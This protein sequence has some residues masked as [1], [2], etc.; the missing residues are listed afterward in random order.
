VNTPISLDELIR[1]VAK[2]REVDLKDLLSSKRTQKISNTRAI[3]SYLAAIE[4]RNSGK[5]IAPY[6]NLSEKSV[7]RCI[8][9]G[10]KLLDKDENLLDYVH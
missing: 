8:E 5:E 3:I 6:L 1:R 7:S 2:D 10:K 4:L 9:R